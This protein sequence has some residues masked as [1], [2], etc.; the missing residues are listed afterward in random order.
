M[1]EVRYDPTVDAMYIKLG[2]GKYKASREVAEGLILDLDG[3]ER[4]IGIEVLDVKERIGA[5]PLSEVTLQVLRR[6]I[7]RPQ[8]RRLK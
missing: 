1:V 5:E 3:E 6:S 2:K 4:L 8:L 7:K